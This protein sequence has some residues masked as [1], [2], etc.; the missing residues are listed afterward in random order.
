MQTPIGPQ[1]TLSQIPARTT[2]LD[3]L[4]GHQIHGRTTYGRAHLLVPPRWDINKL[5]FADYPAAEYNYKRVLQ[6]DHYPVDMD[7]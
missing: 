6:I 4:F 7:L 3:P 2:T 5:R 1:S